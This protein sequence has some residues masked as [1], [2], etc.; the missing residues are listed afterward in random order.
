MHQQSS[1]EFKLLEFKSAQSNSFRADEFASEIG[2]FNDKV[3]ELAIHMYIRMVQFFGFKAE[4]RAFGLTDE[5][6]LGFNFSTPSNNKISKTS[7]LKS[8][9]KLSVNLLYI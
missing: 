1:L 7:K 4:F 6:A 3:I 2:F 8:T 5:K 9:H